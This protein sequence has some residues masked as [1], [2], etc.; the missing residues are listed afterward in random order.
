MRLCNTA[1]KYLKSRNNYTLIIQEHETHLCVPADLVKSVHGAG[2]V[3]LLRVL[4]PGLAGDQPGAAA[5]VGLGP[6]RGSIHIWCDSGQLH[7]SPPVMDSATL[8]STQWIINAA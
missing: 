8:Q 1:M 2:G 5:G 3:L 7:P 6:T 4:L